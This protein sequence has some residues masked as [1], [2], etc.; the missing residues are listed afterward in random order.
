MEIIE[1]KMLR[2]S[3]N[4]KGAELSGLFYKK[5]EMEYLWSGD[6]AFWGK[7]S[8]VLFPIIGTLKGNSFLYNGKS[9]H[10]P[11]HGFARDRVFEVEKRGGDSKTFLLK[12]DMD[13]HK[14]YPF[15]FEFRITYSINEN[16]LTVT[17]DI[18][19]S[20]E[21]DLYFSVGGHPAFKLPLIDGTSY[22]DYYLEFEKPETAGRWPISADGLIEITPL[23]LL[24][25]ASKIPLNKQLFAKDAIVLKHLNS[26]FVKL[27]S[28]KT[29]RGLTFHFP[30]FPYLGLW[31]AKGADFICIDPWCGIAD[32][33]DSDQQLVRK[34]GIVLLRKGESFNRSWSVE[35]Q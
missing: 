29:E 28:N 1:N 10:L 8:P 25:E 5:E 15:D 13:T 33:V 4:P 35:L 11:R 34:E 20:G 17:Y 7:Q 21:G 6:P 19:N 9:Y 22:E 23:P 31:A 16:K 24:N 30:G 3:V 12:S 26:S 27:R 2:V 18:K 14:V 32:P